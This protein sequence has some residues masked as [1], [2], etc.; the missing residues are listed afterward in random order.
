MRRREGV[1]DASCVDVAPAT[2]LPAR[3]S[4]NDAHSLNLSERRRHV[5][6]D[7]IGEILLGGIAIDIEKWDHGDRRKA[8]ARAQSRADGGSAA[9]TQHHDEQSQER[10]ALASR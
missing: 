9:R 7:A 6:A 10:S 5:L 2:E 1:A 4:R 3:R 8:R